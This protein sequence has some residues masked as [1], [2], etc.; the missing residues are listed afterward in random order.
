M[1][2]FR[3][4]MTE[5]VALELG[6]GLMYE[7]TVATY[8]FLG[9]EAEAT[10]NTLSVLTTADLV[11]HLSDSLALVGGVGVSFPLTTQGTYTDNVGTSIEDDFDVKGYTVSGKIGVA[12]GF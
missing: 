8:E 12:L 9:F 2:K 1:A 11:V 7:R 3:A 4:G 10:L 5:M 6:A